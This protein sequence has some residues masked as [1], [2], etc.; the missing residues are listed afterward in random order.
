MYLETHH[1][2]NERCITRRVLEQNGCSSVSCKDDNTETEPITS[3]DGLDFK[4]PC[5]Q[6][7]SVENWDRFI[8]LEKL[9]IGFEV[10]VSVGKLPILEASK[11]VH[12][13][14]ELVIKAN[15][16]NVLTTCAIKS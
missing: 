14:C 13:L 7:R 9:Q 12:F 1:C 10:I 3:V 8:C 16:D 6:V 4:N 11:D 15:T 5:P 2:S